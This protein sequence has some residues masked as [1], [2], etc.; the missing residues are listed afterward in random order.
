[1]RSGNACEAAWTKWK[2]CSKEESAN[3]EHE[4]LAKDV[5]HRKRQVPTETERDLCMP[6][7]VLLGGAVGV[8]AAGLLELLA[9]KLLES[10]LRLVA[11]ALDLLVLGQHPL[12][13][14]KNLLVFLSLH[15]DGLFVVLHRSVGQESG[16]KERRL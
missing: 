12:L 3:E 2:N 11:S 1:M 9:R 13:S 8:A 4:A 16:S 15:L 6:Y 10:H 14:S 5:F 7:L